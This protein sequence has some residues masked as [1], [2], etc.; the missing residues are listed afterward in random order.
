MKYLLLFLGL[1]F[2][3][4]CIRPPT[5][6]KDTLYF[7]E[8]GGSDTIVIDGNACLEHWNSAEDCK[9]FRADH[10]LDNGGKTVRVKSDYCKKNYCRGSPGVIYESSDAAPLMKIECSWY[11]VAFVNENKL[12]VWVNKN[13][14]SEERRQTMNLSSLDCGYVDFTIIQS[15]GD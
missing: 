3:A 6:S 8:E 15:A 12:R 14:T 9:L 4:C 2:F 11:S 5:I 10:N 7:S 13:E 1:I